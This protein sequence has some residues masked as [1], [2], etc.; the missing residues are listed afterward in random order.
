MAVDPI[1]QGRKAGAALLNWGIEL[2]ERTGLPVYFESSPST[3]K[4]YEKMGFER[5]EETIVHEAA[6]MGTEEDIVV[7]LM[8]RMPS[9]A[10]GM[11]FVEWRGRGYPEYV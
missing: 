5:L 1:H 2:G 11:T 6:L 3:V 10:K 4:M 8:V 9:Q 7:P